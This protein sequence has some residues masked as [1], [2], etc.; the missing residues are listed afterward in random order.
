MSDEPWYRDGLRFRCTQCGHCCTIPGYVWVDEE[1]IDRLADQLELDRVDFMKRYVRRVGRR[2]SLVEKANDEC[3]F[4]DAGCTVYAARPRQCRTFPFW[5][6][7]L[8]DRSA[9]NEVEGD[10]PGAGAGRLYSL[11]EVRALSRGAGETGPAT[12]SMITGSDRPLED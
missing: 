4:W 12:G 11:G 6:E 8:R 2:F 3:V 1:E 10:C 7:H 9:W 5:P